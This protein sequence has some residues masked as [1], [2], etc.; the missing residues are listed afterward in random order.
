[1]SEPD[2]E[3][4][5]PA[6]IPADVSKSD[7]VLGPLTAR[8]T[9][10]LAA[11]A[12]LLYGGF[13]AVRPFMPP[14]AY[15]AL[16]TPVGLVMTVIA[17]GRRDGIGLD[18]LLLAAVRFHRS[19][20]R[21]VPA[22]EGVPPLADLVPAAWRVRSGRPPSALRLPCRAVGEDGV[23]DLGSEGR[24][25]LAVCGTLNFHLRTGGEQQALTE[26]FARWLNSLTGPTQLLVRAHRLNPDVLVDELT[27][28]APTLPHPALEQA[29]LAHAAF[30]DS[31]A[32]ERDLLTRQV[33]LIAR[34]ASPAQ[35]AR[36]GHRL[37]EAGRALEAAEIT[38]TALDTDACVRMLRLAADPESVSATGGV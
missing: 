10:I 8:Q 21:Q 36:A 3:T 34:E 35:G 12:L 31:L 13:H 11:T 30:L 4:V 18:R 7:Q 6:K 1:M 32:A 2:D 19:P 9:V 38:V 26:A 15:V 29:A 14:L 28:T 27:E 16:V 20:K 22:P 25:A 5:L 17:V 33:L 24:A 37:A 23:L